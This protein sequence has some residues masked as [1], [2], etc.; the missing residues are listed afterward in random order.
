MRK[1]LTLL[2]AT[3]GGGLGWWL[4]ATVGIMTGFVLSMVGTGFGLY[5]VQRFIRDYLG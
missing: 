4:G 1:L 5:L 2:G 3:L